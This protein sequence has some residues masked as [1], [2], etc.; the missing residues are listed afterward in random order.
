MGPTTRLLQKAAGLYARGDLQ[1]AEELCGQLL[2]LDPDQ[3]DA[4]HIIGLVAWQRGERQRAMDE[5]RKAIASDPGRPQPHNSLG[6]LHKELGDLDAAEAAFRNAIDLMPNHPEALTNLGSILCETGRFADSETTQRR[7]VALVPKYADGHNNLA[8][9]LSK[10]KNWEE[11]AAECQIAVELLPTR[12]EF[13]L[14]LGNALSA[15]ERW[16]EAATAYRHAAALA[17]DNADALAN[18]GIALYRLDRFDEAVQAHRAAAKLRPDDAQIW[19]NLVAAEIDAGKTDAALESSREAL[20]L[21]PDYAEAHNSVGMALKAKGRAMDAIAAFETAIQL[22]PDYDKAYNNLGFMLQAQGRFGESLAAYTKAV[23]LTPDYAAAQ[24]NKGMLHL[25]MGEFE[26]GWRGYEFGLDLKGGRA[27]SRYR[28]YRKWEGVGI[29]GKT[30]VVSAEQG[31]GDQIMFA[32]LLPDL[33]ERGA[34]CLVRLDNRL[35]P[36]LRRSIDG[37][38]PLPHNDTATSEIERFAIDYQAPIGSLCRWLRPDSAAFPSRAGYLRAD[39]TQ[40]HILRNRYRNRLS[41]RPLI[42]ISWRGGTGAVVQVRSIPLA[43]WAPILA[44]STF[45]FVSLQYGDCRADLEAVR[46]DIGVEILHDE[47]VDP[48]KSLDDFAAQTAAMDLVISIDNSTVHMAGALNVPAWVLLPTVPDWRWMLGRSDSLWYS[49]V[50]LFRQAMAGEWVPVIERVA[51]ELM[52]GFGTA[53]R[54]RAASDRPEFD[55][56]R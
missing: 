49:S 4:L 46:H 48:L 24:C 12:T 34:I 6:V 20:R 52:H 55:A 37:L 16:E 53:D 56:P 14:N 31:V 42:G 50:R 23:E 15:L 1:G 27:E 30:I 21:G 25:L 5:I 26:P 18:L 29:A 40:T 36:L 2:E 10:R 7:V 32:S 41:G 8:T 17:P 51:E 43:A 19:V 47:T 33:V 38:T 9:V 3:P 45:G 11:A 35:Q 13:H 28:Q 44:Q 54:D 39:P 22:R